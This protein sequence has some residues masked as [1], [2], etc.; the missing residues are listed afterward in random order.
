[1]YRSP[2]V[3]SSLRRQNCRYA[4]SI[5]NILPVFW[6]Q[7]DPDRAWSLISDS[8]ADPDL[9]LA[10]VQLNLHV[11]LDVTRQKIKYIPELFEFINQ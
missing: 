4:F 11:P 2:S 7:T 3:V 1:M 9:D 10:C 5:Y 6:K 8:D